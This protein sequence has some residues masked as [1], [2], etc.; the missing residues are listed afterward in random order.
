MTKKP[1]RKAA[2]SACG[3]WE[4]VEKCVSKDRKE[5]N[6]EGFSLWVV[7]GWEMGWSNVMK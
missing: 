4:T 5:G 7:N 2:N 1:K 6:E 3:L